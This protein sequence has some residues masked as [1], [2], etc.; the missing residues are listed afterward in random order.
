MTSLQ[1]IFGQNCPY[2]KARLVLLGVPWEATVSYAGGAAEGPK[3]I[4]QAS[5]QLDF[6]D[7]KNENNPSEEG[8]YFQYL[9]HLKDQSDQFRFLA[10]KADSPQDKQKINQACFQMVQ[11]VKMCVKKILDDKKLFGLVGG[12]HSISEGAL[13]EIGE[14]FK[15]DF[16]ILHLDAHADM[17]DSY[18]GFKHSHASVMHNI[19]QNKYAPHTLVQ[20]GVRDLCEEE[21]SKI[22][23]DSRVHCFFDHDVK[24]KLFEGALWADIVSDILNKLPEKIYISLDVDALSWEYAP[25]TG[26]PVPGGFSFDQIV[27]LIHKLV[28]SKKRIIGFDV[29]ETARP[30]SDNFGEWD[31]N[32]SARLIYK[33]CG[34]VL[35]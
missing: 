5:S 24:H 3:W 21:F 8:I 29:V 27:Y 19:L 2:A 31:G 20:A 16:G 7:P 12:D 1:F 4:Q 10:L 17:R 14:R 18:Q 34:A 9:S 35:F 25:H 26:C 33:L 22:Q 23:K 13:L 6:F 32:V 30:I 15:G 28:D 11:E